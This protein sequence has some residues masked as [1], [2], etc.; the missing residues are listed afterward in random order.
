MN[1]R[2]RL[3]LTVLVALLALASFSRFLAWMNLP[4]DLWL[5]SGIVGTALAAGRCSFPDRGYLTSTTALNT[6]RIGTLH[7]HSREEGTS[8]RATSVR[9]R[10][11]QL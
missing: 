5:W 6:T 11:R 1:K 2:I 7:I 8:P 9:R 10:K 3:V 4:S